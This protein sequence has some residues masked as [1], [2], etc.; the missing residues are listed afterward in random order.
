MTP[1][2]SRE[3]E[4]LHLCVSPVSHFTRVTNTGSTRDPTRQNSTRDVPDRWKAAVIFPIWNPGNTANSTSL[5]STTS[6][7]GKVMGKIVNRRLVWILEKNRLRLTNQ[8]GFR[9]FCSLPT[10]TRHPSDVPCTYR[11]IYLSSYKRYDPCTFLGWTDF[12]KNSNISS[13]RN[14]YTKDVRDLYILYIPRMYKRVVSSMY[15]CVSY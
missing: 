13:T 15:I 11:G 7:L 2:P 8:S 12:D 1:A 5:I 3:Q 10:G 14:V 4:V 6:C 9:K